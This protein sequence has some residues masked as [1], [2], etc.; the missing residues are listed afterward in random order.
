MLIE[1]MIIQ[2]CSPT[3]AFIKM[4][5]LFTATF[6]DYNELVSEISSFEEA[7]ENSGVTIKLL[8]VTSNTALVY[9]YRKA[10]LHKEIKNIEVQ[11]FLSSF[12]YINF[13]IDD[14]LSFLDERIKQNNGFPHEIGVF[15]GYPLADVK[16]FILHKGQNYNCV[17]YWKVYANP[18]ES[19]KKFAL[20]DKCRKVY[21]K[22]WNSGRS[23]AQLTVVNTVSSEIALKFV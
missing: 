6:E 4:A 21:Q 19:L 20:F 3:L 9:V 23:V 13:D 2:H 10:L 8:N 16:A 22:L 14:V 7:L 15:L 11:E 18:N 17:G 1:K 5:N 12:G